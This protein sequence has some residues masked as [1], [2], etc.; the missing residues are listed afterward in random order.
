MQTHGEFPPDLIARLT[1]RTSL[2]ATIGRALN[3]GIDI[4]DLVVQ[5]EFTH[6]V[7][8]AVDGVWLV[9]DST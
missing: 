2:H 9:Y 1:A 8:A 4:T 6:D 3:D 5:D 7:I